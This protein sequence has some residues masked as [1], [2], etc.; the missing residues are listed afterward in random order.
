MT[1]RIVFFFGSSRSRRRSAT[2]TSSQPE[3]SSA[4]SIASSL[5][6][7]PVPRNRRERS[8]TPAT[9]RRSACVTVCTGPSLR[10]RVSPSGASRHLPMNGEDRLDGIAASPSMG[11]T[12]LE[13][14][15]QEQRLIAAVCQPLDRVF[16]GQPQQP[17]DLDPRLEPAA[18]DLHD[19]VARDLVA[20]ASV[21]VRGASY[22]P[23]ELAAKAGLFTDLA[24]RAVLWRLVGLDLAL[25]Q[26]PVVVSGSVYDGDLGP[27]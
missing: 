2:V 9:T 10:N 13:V 18:L 23:A 1:S 3:A 25:G 22:R 16:G 17:V 11:R 15:L 19:P 24:Q 26:R 7:L 5:V 6:Y 4:P 8:S 21:D 12:V 27:A 20:A 14:L